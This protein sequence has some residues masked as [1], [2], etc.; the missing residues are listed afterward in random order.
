MGFLGLCD[1][2][3]VI[4]SGWLFG[5]FYLVGGVFGCCFM[6]GLVLQLLCMVISL[7]IVVLLIA[8]SWCV[9]YH[10]FRG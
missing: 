10:L 8:Y 9:W 1:C 3:C 5:L 4:Y 6:S 7:V 2:L